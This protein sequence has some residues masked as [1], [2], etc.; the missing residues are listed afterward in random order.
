ML[1]HRNDWDWAFLKCLN[2]QTN[3]GLFNFYPSCHTWNHKTMNVGRIHWVP[4]LIARYGD[5]SQGNFKEFHKTHPTG[6]RKSN[7]V[8]TP[9]S[10]KVE[11]SKLL[12]QVTCNICGDNEDHI[13]L[14]MI[15]N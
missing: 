12:L 6:G 3:H 8:N 9:S 15:Q 1:G 13:W 11:M 4:T 5:Q 14:A 7:N 10:Y 2:G